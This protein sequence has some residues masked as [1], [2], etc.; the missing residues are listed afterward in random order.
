MLTIF[1]Q[2]LLNVISSSIELK[3]L[4]NVR[5]ITVAVTP[6]QLKYIKKT[7]N[8]PRNSPRVR[9]KVP[10]HT[11]N[12]LKVININRLNDKLLYYYI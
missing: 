3:N 1:L 6:R 12:T 5:K 7:P 8:A 9:N 11:V 4:K 2:D 10:L